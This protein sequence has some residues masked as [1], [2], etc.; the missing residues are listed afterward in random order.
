M[1]L[2]CRKNVVKNFKM[3]KTRKVFNVKDINKIARATKGAN[4]T[5]ESF[6]VASRCTANAQLQMEIEST[7]KFFIKNPVQK[8]TK[9]KEKANML[10]RCLFVN[11]VIKTLCSQM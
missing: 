6:E 4:S 9:K 1:N 7:L 11:Y 2:F 5:T 8:R 3:K 10:W